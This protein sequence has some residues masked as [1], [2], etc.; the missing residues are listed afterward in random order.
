MKF[1]VRENWNL[2][3]GG[4]YFYTRNNSC[5]VAFSIGSLFNRKTSC[6][7]VIGAHTDSPNLRFA[8]NAYGESGKF[9]RVSNLIN[10]K[11][12]KKKTT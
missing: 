4:K 10:R 7:K 5:L 8:P 9:E 11:I 2:Q 3:I 1:N 6:F 12:K